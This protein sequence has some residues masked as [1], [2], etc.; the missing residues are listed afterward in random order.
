MLTVSFHD[1]FAVMGAGNARGG[2]TIGPGAHAVGTTSATPRSGPSAGARSSHVP[3]HTGNGMVIVSGGNVEPG[4][5][6][7][8]FETPSFHEEGGTAAHRRGV[9]TGGGGAGK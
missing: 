3:N 1:R 5:D 7:R 6:R 4:D 9:G 8:W 2:A